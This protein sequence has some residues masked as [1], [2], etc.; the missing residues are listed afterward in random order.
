MIL[1]FTRRKTY[2]I[3]RNVLV[4]QSFNIGFDVMM[5]YRTVI[6]CCEGDSVPQIFIP[7]LV[8]LYKEGKFPVNKIIKTYPFSELNQAK[9]D[10]NSGKVIKAVVTM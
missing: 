8:Q 6:G 2:I 9:A 5:N 7:R 4:W 3:V 10:S 1:R